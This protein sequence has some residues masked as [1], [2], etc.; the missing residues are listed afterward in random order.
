[1]NR[2][3]QM[4]IFTDGQRDRCLKLLDLR[5]AALNDVTSA[6]LVHDDYHFGN[7][8]HVG[9]E[10]TGVLDFEWSFAGDPLYDYTSWYSEEDL[11]PGSREPFLKGCGKTGLSRSERLR[12]DVYKMIG[13][14][15]LCAESKLHFPAEEAA[16][17]QTAAETHLNRL[18]E[19]SGE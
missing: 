2:T 7:L 13:M 14:L 6:K 12:L 10:I 4:G 9:P 1:L 19:H 18:E 5:A 15:T 8:L 17:Y 11:W 3:I 16:Q